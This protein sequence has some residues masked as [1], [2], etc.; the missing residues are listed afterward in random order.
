MSFSE[1]AREVRSIAASVWNDESNSDQRL[2]RILMAA[3]W[4]TWKRVVRKPLRMTLSNGALFRAYPEC[5]CSSAACY[6]RIPSFHQ[7]SVLR[8]EAR[9]GTLV[10]IGA[11][12][13]LISMLLADAFDVGLLFEP[14]PIAAA[15]ARENIELNNLLFEVHEMALS[16]SVGQVE[17]EDRVGYTPATAR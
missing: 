11:N 15:R 7:I 6:F 2:R 12:V 1:S 8:Q 14:N 16:D 5:S 17:F 4:Q 3:G 10:D 9:R 13:G